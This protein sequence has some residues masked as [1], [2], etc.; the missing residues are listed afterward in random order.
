VAVYLDGDKALTWW[1]RN[2]ARTE[3]GIQGWK[4][5][6]IYPD[7]VFAVQS[8]GTAGRIVV[9]E[10]KGDQL[11]NLDTAYKRDLLAFLSEH[12]EWDDGTDAGQLELVT[13]T[14]TIVECTLIFMS[15]WRSKLLKHLAARGGNG[16]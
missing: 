13:E 5:S 10:T 1:H 12:F 4:R 7:F 9:L 14:G 15:E 2:V 3:Y 8:A 16:F 6:K 11:N